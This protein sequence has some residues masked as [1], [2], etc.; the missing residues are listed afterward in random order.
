MTDTTDCKGIEPHSEQLKSTPG[1]CRLL[2]FGLRQTKTKV[3]HQRLTCRM[4]DKTLGFT[5]A[6]HLHHAKH[7]WSS[8]FH[9]HYIIY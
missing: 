2:C 8:E 3:Y 6:S 1:L 5:V 9:T 7:S 4:V